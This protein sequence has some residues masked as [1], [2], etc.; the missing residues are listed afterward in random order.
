MPEA[1]LF[2]ADPLRSRRVEGHFADQADAVR[3]VGGEVALVDHDALLAGDVDRAI[4]RVPHDLGPV[5]YRGWMI[6]ATGYAGLTQAL[7]A[8]GVQVLTTPEAYQQAHELPGWYDAFAEVTPAS[9]WS[10]GVPRDV[11]ALVAPLGTGAGVV[12]DYVKSRKHEWREACFVPDL[13][14]VD[15]AG[16]VI[17][18]FIERQA[19]F[20]A[21]GVVVRAYEQF[22][23]QGE[24]R[25]WW[26]DGEP[27][28]VTS[29]PDTPDQLPEPDLTAVGPLVAALGC[30]FVTTDLARRVDGQWRVVE[31]GD[32]QVSDLSATTAPESLVE[33]LV[34]C[35]AHPETGER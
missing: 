7:T 16:Q 9:V 26:L 31:V 25:V 20:L 3:Q 21:G 2:C 35:S 32:G 34:R 11:R 14:D 33:P 8:R 17:A 22:D 30:R 12:K 28:L 23:T 4:R 10:V 1:F 13:L 5:W 27:F 15:A 24:A 19:E 6:P 18:T 29:H